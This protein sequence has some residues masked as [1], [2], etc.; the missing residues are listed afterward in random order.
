MVML[1]G[2]NWVIPIFRAR[3]RGRTLTLAPRSHRARSM[4]NVPSMHG[5]LKLPG[6]INLGGKLRYWSALHSSVKATD[7]ALGRECLRFRRPL[8]NLM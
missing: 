8:R 1:V 6:S 3:D 4:G 7:S 5:I 2:L